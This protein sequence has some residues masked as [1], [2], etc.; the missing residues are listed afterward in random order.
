MRDKKETE[1]SEKMESIDKPVEKSD[2]LD[3]IKRITYKPFK[4]L[5]QQTPD[6]IC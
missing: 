5:Y 4:D 6:E 1:K 3:E 2:S